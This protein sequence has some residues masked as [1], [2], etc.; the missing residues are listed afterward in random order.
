MRRGRTALE[1]HARAAALDAAI[2]AGSGDDPSIMLYTSGTTG[3]SKGVVLAAGR[4]V[5]AARDTVAFD[6]LTDADEQLAYLPLAWV[7]DH[8]MNYAQGLVAGFCMACPENAET[9]PSDLKEIGPSFYFAPPRVF[10]AQLT[11][12][13][14]RMEDASR[15]KRALFH[16]FLGHARK[17]GEKILNGEHVPALARL[18]YALGEAVIYAPL[19]N[20]LGLSRVR[21]AYTAGEAIGSE[22]FSF[23]R[24]IGLNLKQLYGQ[25]EA[26]LYVTCHADGHVRSDTVGAPAPNVDIRIAEDGEVQFKS[27]GQFVEYFH[28]P[29]KTAE[30]MTSDGYVKTGDAGFFDP[31]GQLRIIDRAKDVGKLLDGNLFAPKYIE[32]KL[33]FFP[34]IKEAVAFGDGRDFRVG[35]AQHRP[36]LGR[37]LGRAQQC[38]LCLLS[39]T[40]GPARRRRD[41]VEACRGGERNPVARAENGRHA[42]QALPHPAQGAGRRRRRTD[43]HPESAA[44]LHRRALRR[45]GE[46]A[47]RR[48]ERAGHL[49]ANDLRGRPHRH[50]FRTGPN[51]RREDLPAG[52]G[53]G[54]G[55]AGRGQERQGAGGM[56]KPVVE[57]A[58]M[59]ETLLAVENVSLSFGGVKAITNVSFDIRKG[60]IRAII[61][62]NG[63]GKTSML[64]VI[65]GFY[66]PQL[67]RITY[68]GETRS[69]MKPHKAARQGI[70]RTFQNVALF[71]GMTTLDNIM[72]GRNLRMKRGF[73]WQ[74]LRFGPA[75]REEIEHRK[76]CE[77]IIDFLEIE[78]IRKTPVGKLPYGLQKRVELGRALAMEPDLLLLDEP[79]A[80][81]N[82]EE[83]E[84]MSR[85][86]IDVNQ[87][88]G[89]TIALIEHDIGVVMDLS[90]RIVVLEY[91]HKI[92]DGTPE[93]VKADQKVIDA[94]LGVAH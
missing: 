73:F 36:V 71:K 89:A 56:N 69:Q 54:Q 39:G 26:F 81:M 75:M 62:P 37:Q 68:K 34:N 51:P 90:D 64:N 19:K 87:H 46:R 43:P 91:G 76:F 48:L 41:A 40:G 50:D 83:K 1:N 55:A 57:A 18:H 61:G 6:H 80:G 4:S 35:H 84:D 60:E 42:D 58:L 59:R 53:G 38:L 74:A 3:R 92:A 25:T 49:H 47:L 32:N 12:I 93:E 24:S 79:M 20:A 86:I 15:L 8:Y 30:A 94:Y 9:V 16:H 21:V 10:E 28:E 33:K 63:A 88:F 72:I 66:H 67:G 14:I 5:A 77:E 65:N 78:H 27:P 85:F 13:M 45:A 29:E 52:P 82:L 23:Y 22:L 70:A 31:D 7:G 2:D 44:R 17:W 11:R